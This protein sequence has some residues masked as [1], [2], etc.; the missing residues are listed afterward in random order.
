[1]LPIKIQKFREAYRR[2]CLKHNLF[3]D[4]QVLEACR[5]NMDKLGYL[6]NMRLSL[7][8]MLNGAY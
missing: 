4:D 6:F 5:K 3:T 7:I 1:M 2:E 8:A